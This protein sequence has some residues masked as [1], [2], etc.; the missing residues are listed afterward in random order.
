MRNFR[1]AFTLGFLLGLAPFLAWSQTYRGSIR[2][3]VVDAAGAAVVGAAIDTRNLSTNAERTAVTDAQGEFIVPE[4]D[5]GQYRVEV[6]AAGFESVAEVTP[7][8]VGHNAEVDLTLGKVA[9]TTQTV[10]VSEQAP[11]LETANSTLGA[12]VQDR[13]V[14]TL[15]L[16]GRDFGKLVAV[17]PGVT[18]EGSGVA[19]TEKGFGQFNINGNRDR[20]NNYLLDGTDDNDPY[21][22]NSALNQVGITGAPASLLPLDAIQEF[23][24]QTSYGAEYGR[25]AGGVVNIITKSGTNQFHGDVFGYFRNNIFD[26]RNY[27]NTRLDQDGNPNPQSPFRNANFGGTLGGPIVR[28]RTFFFLA[29]E[30]QREAAGSDFLL[31]LPTAD[32]I[33]QA[34]SLAVANGAAPNPGLDHVL[35]YFPSTTTGLQ[36]VTVVDQ[37]NLDSFIAKI[38]QQLSDREQLAVRYAFS[39]GYQQFPLGSLGGYGSGSRL[40]QFAQTSPTRVQVLSASLLSV[41]RPALVNE[42]RFGYSRYRTSFSSLDGKLD[43]ASIGLD[44]GTQDTGLPEFDFSGVIENLGATAYS[45]PRGRVS[46][47]FQGLD[48]LTWTVGRHTLKFGAEYRFVTVNSFNDNLERGLLYF[49]PGT[50]YD[51]NG[52]PVANQPSDPVVQVL[53]NFYLGSGNGGGAYTGNTQRTTTNKNV[54]A[55]VQDTYQV[56]PTLTLNYGLRWEYFGPV[57]ETHGLLSNLGSDGLLAMEGTDGVHGAFNRNWLNFSPRLG[58]AWQPWNTTVVRGSYGVYYDYTPQDVLIANYTNSAGLTLNPIGPKP[59]LPLDFNQDTYAGNGSGPFYTPVTSGPYDVFVTPRHMPTPYSQAWNLN[60]QQELN[61]RTSFEVVYI[62]SKGTH[63][64]RLYDANQPDVTDTRPNPNFGYEDTFADIA[65]SNY[66]SLQTTLRVRGAKGVSGLVTY[67]WSKSLDTAS[68]GIDFNSATA[69][70][71]QDSNNLAAEYGPST[72]D[73]RHRFTVALTYDVPVLHAVPAR[74]GSGWSFATLATVQSGRP[75]PITTSTDTTE[76]EFADDTRDSYHQRPN[77]V[78]GVSPV[79]ANWSPTHGYLNPAAFSQ[80]GYNPPTPNGNGVG[81][82]GDLG[83]DEVFGPA[84]INWD[85]SLIKDTHITEAVVLQLR[86]EAFNVLNHPNFALPNGSY[87]SDSFGQFSQTPDVAQGNP[88]LGGGGPRVLQLAARFTF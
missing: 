20:S 41:I 4:L 74:V 67:N 7:V 45:V 48:N 82:F 50:V 71:P 78:P 23:N 83:R 62:G 55:F 26:A 52:N 87:G 25:N 46:Q 81:A 70:L 51:L 17:T 59:I 35:S 63:L 75:I 19:G 57:D 6:H 36:N 79:L 21:F 72:F 15:P 73:T 14:Q 49:S 65:W 37:N 9:S 8:D 31:T 11:V 32:E 28:N 69:A 29:Y 2:G 58:F 10:T 61:A 30:G 84:F 68:D 1:S 86:A 85:T 60:V 34:R 3:R 66:N 38:D 24:I 64:S 76:D 13:M 43:P 27:F 18:V 16:N 40:P 77:V 47:T 88:G 5:A 22:N 39:Q 56:T 53:A 12:V 80:P 44:T 33:G 54:G 42:A